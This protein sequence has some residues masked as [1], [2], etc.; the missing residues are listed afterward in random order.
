[1][2]NIKNLTSQELF[3]ERLISIAG[4]RKKLATEISKLLQITSD[5]AYR[6]IR[7]ETAMNFEEIVQ[8]A[9]HYSISI[10]QI[11]GLQN[12]GKHVTFDYLGSDDNLKD[13]LNFH[14][15][16]FSQ[17]KEA[18][19]VHFYASCRDFSL[20]YLIYFPE[21]WFF[22]GYFF[23][24]II[25]NMDMMKEQQFS[26]EKMMRVLEHEGIE[27]SNFAHLKDNAR[28]NTKDIWNY[29]T[30]KGHLNQIQYCWELGYFESKEI[31]LRLCDQTM[32]LAKH[33][34][35]QAAVGRKFRLNDYDHPMGNYELYLNDAIPLEYFV[36]RELDN[37]KMIY[38]NSNLG[39]YLA[40]SDKHYCDRMQDYIHI[41]IRKSSQIS[42]ANERSRNH[43]F[44]HIYK[45][46]EELTERIK[47]D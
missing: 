9:Q 34:Q 39:E 46:I 36:L 29:D 11:I 31:A 15:K 16:V 38:H 17:A 45:Q 47:K 3:F 37:E 12:D 42:I 26:P 24:K 35:K 30:F 44:N 21:L 6:R 33:F 14:A 18:R 8:L 4:T 5:G 40:T 28:Y 23:T 27:L 7:S 43:L 41:L 22:K 25:W 20:T 13:Y 1:M 10:D 2:S 32:Q 19:T